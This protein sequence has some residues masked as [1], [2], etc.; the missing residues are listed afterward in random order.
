MERR[1]GRLCHVEMECGFLTNN[2]FIVGIGPGRSD[3]LTGEARRALEISEE[4][5]GYPVYTRL[6]KNEFPGKKYIETGMGSE[7][8]RCKICFE[9]AVRGKKIAIV[10]SG[11]AGI[12]GMAS[13]MYEISGDYPGIELT[14]IPGLTAAI[15]GAAVLGAPLS[16]DF[17][18]ISLSDILTPWEKIEK[19]LRAAAKG[20]FTIVLYNPMSHKRVEHLK[21]ACD[22]LLEYINS[23][24]VCGWVENIGREGEKKAYLTLCELR[25]AELSMFTTVFIGS[26]E[27]VMKNGVMLTKRGYDKKE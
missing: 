17:A 19:R 11:D 1:D 6:L 10:S 21:R 16:N 12:Y 4:I 13:L 24:R 8:E 22:I 27:T 3:A 7:R 5:I 26:S 2:I 14:V 23:E 20:D 25:E 15:T 18:I 9:E